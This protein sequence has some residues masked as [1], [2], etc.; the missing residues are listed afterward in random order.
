MFP[1][2]YML[3]ASVSFIATPKSAS[4]TCPS[5]VVNMLAPLISL[6]NAPC[7]CRYFKPRRICLTY[8]ATRG[9]EKEPNFFSTVDNDPF[10]IYLK[11]DYVRNTS[12]ED[13]IQRS[14][15]QMVISASLI[16][17]IAKK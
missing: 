11:E 6:C 4:L 1:L 15:N 14:A 9:S 16:V 2:L 12:L 8:I 13:K 3:L 5:F 10:S 7:S 17:E